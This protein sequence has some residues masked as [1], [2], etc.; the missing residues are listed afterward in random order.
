MSVVVTPGTRGIP[1]S[2]QFL[3]VFASIALRH[4]EDDAEVDRPPARGREDDNDDDDDDDDEG[5]EPRLILRAASS[6][7]SDDDFRHGNCDDDDGDVGGGGRRWRRRR[8][9]H[10]PPE[11]LRQG[12]QD[13]VGRVDDGIGIP[14]FA[15]KNVGRRR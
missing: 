7:S 5:S 14:L 9:C 8:G 11:T 13:V 15:D 6:T 1:S 10:T 3:F 2:F 12:V 4:D